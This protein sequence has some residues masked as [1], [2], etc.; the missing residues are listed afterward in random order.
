M[1]KKIKKI[2]KNIGKSIKRKNKK[3]YS[4]PF[5]TIIS[6][7]LILL[8]VGF[9]IFTNINV[10]LKKVELT[11]RTEELRKEVQTLE[12]KRQELQAKIARAEDPDFLEER[13][14]EELGLKKP[15]EEVVVIVSSPEKE[16]EEPVKEEKTFWQKIQNWFLAF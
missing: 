6:G 4:F 3:N 13:F 16:V 14:R 7:F 8:V 11:E 2:N 1:K 9:L 12:Q 5:F 15:G 10:A